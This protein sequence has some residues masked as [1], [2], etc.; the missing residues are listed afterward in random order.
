MYQYRINK[1]LRI[2][3][4]DTLTVEVDL[5]FNV[6][7][8]V[9]FKVARVTTPELDLDSDVDPTVEMRKAIIAWFR[10]HPKPWTLQTYK[11][12]SGYTG[13]VLDD[14]GSI[15]A[16]DLTLPKTA[17]PTDETSVIFGLPRASEDPATFN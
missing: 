10:T 7:T 13:D 8:Q 5:G 14:K 11:D 15:L 17:S 3:N 6:T 2:T 4:S 1:L 16:D 9:T 12:G